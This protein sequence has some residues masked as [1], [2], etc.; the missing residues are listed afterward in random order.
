MRRYLRLW[1]RFVILAVVREAEYRMNFVFGVV[2]GLAQLALAVFTF[3]LVYR[4][5]D[6][7]AGWAQAQVLVLV[8][9]YRIVDGLISLQ[10]SPNLNEVPD[11]IRR[12]E[13]DFVLLRPVSSQ[14]FVSLRKLS[15]PDLV[16]ATIG[17]IIVVIAGYRAGIT[18][19]LLGIVEAVAFL[20]CGVLLLYA[21]WFFLVTW[22]FWLINVGTMSYLF[23]TATEP[24]RYPV[25]YFKGFVRA[26]LTF[27]IPVA[28]ATT[29]PAQ[30]LLGTVDLRMLPIGITMAAIALLGTHVFWNF[31]V[32]H[33]SS[34]S[35]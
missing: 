32:R 20:T 9:I 3:L 17:L 19:N 8:G 4:Y 27:A 33:Y 35:S 18:W 28:F 11:T 22:A 5:T 1:R 12:G 16:N 34:A 21:L 10:I 7:V 30:A 2:E 23:Y 31:A 14:F 24:A 15:L 6:Q 25:T 26:L 13:M 29:F